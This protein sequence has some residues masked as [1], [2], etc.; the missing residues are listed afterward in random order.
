MEHEV[1]PFK[2]PRNRDDRDE[3]NEKTL[4]KLAYRIDHIQQQRFE[5]RMAAFWRILYLVAIASV[6]SFA[7]GY[8][9]GRFGF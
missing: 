5:K 9:R 2:A 4:W 1:L 6:I 8:H 3:R 7:L